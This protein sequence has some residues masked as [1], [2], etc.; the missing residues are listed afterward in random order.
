MRITY[1]DAK[2]RRAYLLG[3]HPWGANYGTTVAQC[4]TVKE[5]W[6]VMKF[7]KLFQK[8]RPYITTPGF[9][10][11]LWPQEAGGYADG[12]TARLLREPE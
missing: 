7:L 6:L 8:G 4:Y 9:R 10:R 2:R 5:C 12:R 3:L 11:F 1:P